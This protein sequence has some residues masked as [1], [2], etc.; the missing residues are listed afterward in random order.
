MCKIMN[1][2]CRCSGYDVKRNNILLITHILSL[3]TDYKF[4]IVFRIC[5]DNLSAATNILILKGMHSD[6]A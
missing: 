3:F 1:F 6:D 2:C 5:L 4:M